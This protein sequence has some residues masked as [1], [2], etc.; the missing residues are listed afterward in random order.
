MRRLPPLSALRAFEAAARHGSFKLAANELAVTATAVS[1]QIR[2]L[3]EYTGLTLFERQVRKVVL[4]AA[5]S[6][7]YPVLRDGFNAFEETLSR[8]GAAGDRQQVTI[9]ATNAFT[10]KWLAPRVAGF[11]KLHPGV[12]LLLHAMRG[13][14]YKPPSRDKA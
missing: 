14:R 7:L 3:E 6:Q 1:H 12:D 9:S 5:G 8:L 11:S 13:T 4:T 2:F 10:A